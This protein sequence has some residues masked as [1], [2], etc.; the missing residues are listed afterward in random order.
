[1]LI[2]QNIQ[3]IIDASVKRTV[4]S[5]LLFYFLFDKNYLNEI[6]EKSVHRLIYLKSITSFS[7]YIVNDLKGPEV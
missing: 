3:E 1:M 2:Q 4:G 5:H 7:R 6:H